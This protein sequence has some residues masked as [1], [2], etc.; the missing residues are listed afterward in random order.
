MKM[1]DADDFEAW[2]IDNGK[3]T[4]EAMYIVKLTFAFMIATNRKVEKD[5]TEE[6]PK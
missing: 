5:L 2:L 6:T 4:K 1:S 3:T